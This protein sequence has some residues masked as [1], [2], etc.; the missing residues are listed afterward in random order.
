L[1]LPLRLSLFREKNILRIFILKKEKMLMK[2]PYLILGITTTIII[3]AFITGVGIFID[4]PLPTIDTDRELYFP[5]ETIQVISSWNIYFGDTEELE[6]VIIL[7][8]YSLEQKP[9]NLAVSDAFY[10][11][12]SISC[13][14]QNG[15]TFFETNFNCIN[16]EPGQLWASLV[17]LTFN[18]GEFKPFESFYSSKSISIQK[19]NIT[20]SESFP[21]VFENIY[22]DSIHWNS[23]IYAEQNNS[24][25]FPEEAILLEIFRNSTLIYSENQ[26]ID[27]SGNFSLNFSSFKLNSTGN[28]ILEMTFQENPLFNSKSYLAN[29]SIMERNLRFVSLNASNI[30]LSPCNSD[31]MIQ[32]QLMDDQNLIYFIEDLNVSMDS[33]LNLVDNFSFNL[34][35][36]YVFQYPDGEETFNITLSGFSPVYSISQFA[37]SYY[38]QKNHLN[39]ALKLR[40]LNYN[41]SISF[42][43]EGNSTISLTELNQTMLYLE[44]FHSDFWIPLN[45][46]FIDIYPTVIS[47]IV[48]WSIILNVIDVRSKSYLLFR[49]NYLEDRFFYNYIS[50]NLTTTFS[51]FANF[52]LN[53][54]EIVEGQKVSFNFNGFYLYKP[55]TFFWDFGDETSSTEE[56]P[57]HYFESPGI[58]SI[59]LVIE[60]L[61]G[62][63]DS[64]LQK[65]ILS[66]IVNEIPV[67]NFNIMCD[68]MIQNE[69]LLFNFTGFEGNG[70]A[71]FY[72]DF[73]DGTGSSLKAPNKVFKNYG[74]F[75]ISLEVFDRNGEKAKCSENLTIGRD[76]YPSA[77]FQ[78]EETY[79]I[80][81]QIVHFIFTG[82]EG[83][84]NLVFLW[85]FGDGLGISHERNPSYEYNTTGIF[86]VRLYIIDADQDF[87]FLL[88]EKYV[89]VAEDLIPFANFSC[90]FLHNLTGEEI[91]FSFSGYE[92]NGPANFLWDFGDGTSSTLKDPSH[93]YEMAGSFTIALLVSDF[94]EDQSFVSWVL[95]IEENF[96][97][98]V[99]FTIN[100]E[101]LIEM[102]LIQFNFTGY[103]GNGPATFYWN[104]G[105]GTN[106]TLQNPIHSF[107]QAGKFYVNLTV[108]DKNGDSAS[109]IREIVVEN[110]LKPVANFSFS[111]DDLIKGEILQFN[112]TGYEGN[113]PVYF[114]WDFGDG[115]N[116]TLRNPTN[117]YK[118]TGNF[119]IKLVIIDF[120]GDSALFSQNI[121][122]SSKNYMV[123]ITGF[124]VF[125]IGVN[126]YIYQKKKKHKLTTQVSLN[127]MKMK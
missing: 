5:N 18:N 8:N 71:D 127:S 91:F 119:T 83:N 56:N 24:I 21:E 44:I 40:E 100:P 35:Y 67:A 31:F 25:N 125:G 118:S 79:I 39:L 82:S 117:S 11:N 54:F 69:I 59:S 95:L 93:I 29:L 14:V 16:I 99:L 96:I 58:Y 32:F 89:E 74:I 49:L 13:P 28:F 107:L 124:F 86:N 90:E 17:F 61:E 62:K 2:K 68:Y 75:N 27:N 43:I 87:D 105:D 19:Y 85:D 15:E 26:F 121:D 45:F 72:W 66:V 65:D 102:D 120:D 97:P 84:G 109:Q 30:S 94:N 23:M 77:N 12:L 46:T 22:G 115:T 64:I 60:D 92:G 34:I 78:T 36:S 53:Q 55:I 110:D 4:N 122:I 63:S 50:P 3:S 37:E 80:K 98:G 114:Y 1:I 112:F 108:L 48:D 6:I 20:T 10:L 7:S 41:N 126:T 9:L 104:F 103:V 123:P 42:Y 106:S 88:K 113:G 101:I 111:Y 116:S 73:G 70:P 76:Y 33:N 81:S 57:E 51:L 52:S 38:F 47:I